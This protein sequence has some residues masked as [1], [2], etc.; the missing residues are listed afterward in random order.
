MTQIDATHD[1]AL[2]S[3][4]PGADLHPDFP[5]Q[6]L[7]FGIVSPPGGDRRGGVAIGDRILD[8]RAALAAGLFAGEAAK[9]AEAAASDTLNGFFALGAGP[10]R[11]VRTRLSALLAE[12]SA[13]RDAAA[14]CLHAAAGCTLHLPARIG[15]Y[16]DFYVG[17]HHATN[18]GRVFRPDNPLLPNYK[19]VPI[20]YHGRAS[21]V[22]VSG[23]DL[24]RPK[25]QL[26]PPDAA[27]PRFGPCEKLDYELELGIWIGPGNALGEPVPVGAAE[28]HV[29]GFCLLNDWSA[30]DIQA[31][32]YQPLGPFLSKSF[33]STISP[34]VITPE[35]LAPFRIAQPPR[36]EGDPTPL[37]YLLDD[38]DQRGGGFDIALEV[39]IETAAMRAAGLPPH[40]LS[41]SGTRHMYWTV[42]QM[43][44]HHTSGGCDLNP[45]D[46]FGSGTLSAPDPAGLGSL[47]ET[48]RGGQAPVALPGGET[49]RFL[50]DGDAIILRARAARPGAVSIGFGE[51]RARIL[52]AAGG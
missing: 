13:E 34:W 28:T 22:R 7:P 32:E 29:A 30:R 17:I 44:A 12:G 23:T 18:V 11:A 50:E 1:P 21:S 43:V 25:G 6:N 14:A 39:L 15:D 4:V 36:P 41:L 9:A 51:C 38:A 3:W 52:P 5:I 19:H 27:A 46:L 31:W 20:G 37:P 10:R 40:R 2:R 48:T 42:A 35:A 49:R 47:L 16:T 24:R 26:K 45:G 8:L 33:G